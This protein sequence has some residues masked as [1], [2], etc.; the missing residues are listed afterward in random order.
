MI[1]LSNRSNR[2]RVTLARSLRGGRRSPSSIP[3][4]SEG[5]RQNGRA[6]LPLTAAPLS[7]I[8]VQHKGSADGIYSPREER[9]AKAAHLSRPSFYSCA[10]DLWISPR[11]APRCKGVLEMNKAHL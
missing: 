11:I 6:L 1:A 9:Q 10:P 2:G 5:R 4:S 7:C 8:A 3:L